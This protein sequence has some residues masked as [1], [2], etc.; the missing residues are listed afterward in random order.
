MLV[1]I[2]QITLLIAVGQFVFGVA[3]GRS[4]LAL[5][6]MVITFDLAAVSLGILPSTLVKTT[7]QAV[8]LMLGVSMTMAALGGAWWP[9]EIVPTTMQRIGYLFP[10]AWAMEGFQAVILRG[11]GTPEVALPALVLLS[12]ALLFFSL[13]IWRF[14]Y[15]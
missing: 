5:A 2:L 12:F 4:P 6:I 3:W 7:E 1:G 11:A 9:L 14:R 15:E 13:G 10:V 8:G